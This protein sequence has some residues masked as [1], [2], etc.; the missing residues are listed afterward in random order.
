MGKIKNILIEWLEDVGYELGY[1]MDN[2]QDVYKMSVT[3]YLIIHYGLKDKQ[4]ELHIMKAA[5]ENKIR[6]IVRQEIEAM[7]NCDEALQQHLSENAN[8]RDIERNI[9]N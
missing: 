7:Y 6:K 3:D 2:Y 9:G 8:D 5:N 4:N 1:D